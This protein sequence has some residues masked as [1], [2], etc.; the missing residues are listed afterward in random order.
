MARPAAAS[1]GGRVVRFLQRTT[2]A[3]DLT[4]LDRPEE[5]KSHSQE[6]A[7]ASGCGDDAARTAAAVPPG[8]RDIRARGE[9]VVSWVSH[10]TCGHRTA[11]R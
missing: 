4:A 3:L 9:R 8:G 10:Q 2:S 11:R 5:P 6:A 1:S 7:Q